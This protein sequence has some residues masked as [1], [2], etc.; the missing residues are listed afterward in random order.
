MHDSESHTS[1]GRSAIIVALAASI[2]LASILTFGLTLKAAV[3]ACLGVVMLA[4]SVSD[5]RSFIIPDVL[6]LPAIPA[7]LIATGYLAFPDAVWG[8]ILENAAAMAIGA[9]GLLAVRIGYRAWRGF[10][11]LGLG[12][13][14][15]AAA[16]GAW[17]GVTGLS[18][19][20]LLA[21]LGAIAYLLAAQA[22]AKAEFHRHT[23]VPFGAFLAPSIWFT[24]VL[25][26]TVIQTHV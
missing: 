11:G 12:D 7:G 1:N 24:W 14:K 10:D 15:L 17:T 13:V 6:S 2:A 4:I 26:E 18:L 3:S 19:L 16:G 20:L 9:I 21:C 23:R 22:F 5:M 8:R 25:T